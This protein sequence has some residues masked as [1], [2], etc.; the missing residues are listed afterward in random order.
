MPAPA[1]FD[2]QLLLASVSGYMFQ[3]TPRV[4]RIH[5][6]YLQRE[7]R[8][9]TT[10]EEQELRLLSGPSLPAD[11]VR[12][13]LM[14]ADVWGGIPET[15]EGGGH[16]DVRQGRAKGPEDIGENCLPLLQVPDLGE[17]RRRQHRISGPVAAT[18]NLDGLEGGGMLPSHSSHMQ[19]TRHYVV[20]YVG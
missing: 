3:D 2:Q 7:P 1:I 12:E 10:Y 6:L 14:G 5:D 13:F 17:P 11:E 19:V 8:S 16:G 18:A 9:G 20:K 4:E 15:D